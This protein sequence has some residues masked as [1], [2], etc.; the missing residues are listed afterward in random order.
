[1]VAR[2]ARPSR[3]TT[4]GDGLRC[5]RVQRDAERLARAAG[6]RNGAAR[7]LRDTVVS[8][9]PASATTRRFRSVQ[10]EDPAT[11]LRSLTRWTNGASGS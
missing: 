4:R 8:R 10:Q 11:L 9:T 6:M 7:W 2:S 5:G 3:P 1:M